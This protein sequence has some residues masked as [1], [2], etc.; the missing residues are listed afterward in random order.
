MDID[1]VLAVKNFR[2]TKYDSQGK[3]V[4]GQTGK[5]WCMPVSAWHK[6]VFSETKS[7]IVFYKNQ[8]PYLPSLAEVR[9]T[10][11]WLHAAGMRNK[12][13]GHADDIALPNGKYIPL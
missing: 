6:P 1:G 11:R 3:P 4:T 12:L 5:S 10:M 7:K 13:T 9:D 2:M 8:F